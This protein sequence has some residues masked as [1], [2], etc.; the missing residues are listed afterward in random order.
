M[1]GDQGPRLSV[2]AVIKF[3]AAYPD[4]SIRLFGDEKRIRAELNLLPPRL[5]IVHADDEVRMED[6][7]AQAL[8]R[9]QQSSMWC[10]LANVAEGQADACISAGNTG[11]LMAIGRHLLKTL[12]GIDR[13]AICKPMPTA[14]RASYLL[15]LG[16]NLEC[17]AEQLFQFAIMGS[18]LAK[19]H[20]IERPEIAL[21][22]VGSEM[23]KGSEEVQRA[24]ELIRG[25]ESL[26]FKGFIEGDE[27][28]SGDVDVV[29]CDGFVG[30]VALKVS[31]GLARFVFSS[32]Q[33]YLR[34]SPFKRL[35]VFF[36]RPLFLG[37]SNK[38]NPSRYNGAILLGLKKVVIKSHGGTSEAG[39]IKALETAREQVLNDIPAQIESGLR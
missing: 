31:E 32:L 11:A 24:A 39:F 35:L 34:A 23:T 28:Y 10:A 9:K 16:A 27:L 15:D 1:G 6:K 13:P 4:T 14:K 8:R 12:E 19:I 37:W 21:L 2:A 33:E 3:L 7:P 26:V 5:E 29:V 30:N 20:G 25:Q 36:I 38:F 18:A 22:N 17:S